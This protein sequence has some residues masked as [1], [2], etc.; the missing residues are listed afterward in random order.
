VAA[1]F[2]FF[3]KLYEQ[4]RRRSWKEEGTERTIAAIAG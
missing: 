1:Y 2:L 3:G 4:E